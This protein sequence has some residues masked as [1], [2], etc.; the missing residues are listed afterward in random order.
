MRSGNKAGDESKEVN[1]GLVPKP[2]G[3]NIGAKRLAPTAYQAA[4][5]ST[6]AA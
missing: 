3:T 4:T 5:I 6:R 1:Q 2:R